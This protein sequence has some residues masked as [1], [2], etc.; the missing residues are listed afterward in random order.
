MT[1]NNKLIIVESPTKAKTISSFLKGFDILPSYGHIRDLPKNKLGIDLDNF[2]V[3]YVIIPKAKENLK[4]IEKQ[5][6]K[7]TEIILATDEDR[8]GE[9]IAWHLLQALNLDENKTKRIVFHEITKPAIEEALKNPRKIKIELINAQQ[10]RRVLDRLVGYKLSPF[11]WRKIKY[12]L[13]AGRVQSAALRL[14]CEK[15]KEIEDF[16]SQEYWTISAILEKN[17][18]TFEAQLFKINDKTLDKLEI[19]NEE[20]AKEISQKIK[21][22][23][24]S[25]FDLKQKTIF[26]SPFPPF[27]TSTLQQESW[28]KLRFSSKQT[29]MLAQQLYE[30]GL[31]TYMRTDSVNISKQAIAMV[32]K[33]IEQEFGKDYLPSTYNIYK[34]K[35]KLSQEAHEA[36]RP[37]DINKTSLKLKD[38]LTGQQLKLYE[39][40]WKRFVACQM[41]KATLKQT[42][43]IV[44]AQNKDDYFLKATGEIIV[45]DGFLKIFPKKQETILPSLEKDDKLKLL[46]IKT[47]QH[48]TQPPA[49]YND[50]SLV[51]KLE[52]LGIGRPST[53]AS[54]I[55]TLLLRNYI[56]RNSSR[57]FTPTMLGKL[58]NDLLVKHFKDI[59]NY[60]FTA[61]IENDLDRIAQGEKNWQEVVKNFY[62]PFNKNLEQ[63]EKEVS[64]REATEKESE[65]ICEKCG[66][67][68]VVKYGKYGPFL[69]C[70]NYPNCSNIKKIP[71]QNTELDIPCPK[72]GK[73]EGGKIVVRKTKTKKRTFY[74][75][76]R[77]PK[78]DFMSWKL[79]NQ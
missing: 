55:S 35:S 52:E 47:L 49:R 71:K 45:F 70:S 50:A 79:P 40:I 60:E 59:V 3:E 76:S 24:F 19:K 30:Q 66:S 13:S 17:N 53:Y 65:E 44:K 62:E 23:D 27:T 6:R 51:K 5:A 78:C 36:I 57:A 58:V 67:K 8:E 10:A 9:A 15:E 2:K 34:T 14:I 4:K 42:T 16:I 69:A 75:C 48:F 74:G 22:A 72:C 12:G 1:K 11:L 20:G 41:S 39:L 77:W 33:F 29:M 21:Q 32:R 46:E 61:T 73:T 7:S 64:R 63:K 68:M 26:N 37:T 28:Q 43:V 38:K 18:Q 31:I 56:E 54:I 25:V